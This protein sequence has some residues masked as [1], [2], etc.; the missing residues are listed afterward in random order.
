MFH[1][2]KFFV[3]FYL[4]QMKSSLFSGS[5]HIIKTSWT[6]KVRVIKLLSIR[7]IQLGYCVLKNYISE[8]F[9]M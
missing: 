1:E 2:V 9:L 5:T 6:N 7:K 8:T 3:N 4:L